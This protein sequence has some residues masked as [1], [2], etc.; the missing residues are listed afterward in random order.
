VRGTECGFSIPPGKVQLWFKDGTSTNPC[1]NSG[2]QGV[3]FDWSFPSH[4]LSSIHFFASGRY[5][6]MVLGF[7]YPDSYAAEAK[8]AADAVQQF[9]RGLQDELGAIEK[10]FRDALVGKS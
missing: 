2:I 3:P 10:A 8:L 6:Q 9:A 7:R 1:G 5:G 4:I